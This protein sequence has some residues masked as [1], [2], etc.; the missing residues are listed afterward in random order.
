MKL[1]WAPSLRNHAA[2]EGFLAIVL[3]ALPMLFAGCNRGE[4]KPLLTNNDPSAGSNSV[5]TLMAAQAPLVAAAERLSK[6]DRDGAHLGGIKLEV[7]RRAVNVWWK[8]DPPADLR[9]EI[10]RQQQGGLTIN[11]QPA[12][13]SQK[14]L[15]Q[16]VQE[17]ASNFEA[18]PGLAY[19]GPIADGSGL[20]LGVTDLKR[21][22][23][24]PKI[25]VPAK[26]VESSVIKATTRANDSPPWWGGAVTRAVFPGA[27][28]CSTGFS[29]GRWSWGTRT[30][31]GILT[32]NH[33]APGGGVLFN[34]GAGQPIGMAEP[35][36]TGQSV[37]LD[38]LY[39]TTTSSG[40]RIFDGGVGTG[41]FTKP[42]LGQTNS[43]PG[44][45][46]CTSGAGTGVHCGIRVDSIK[47]SAFVF[48]S[49]VFSQSVAITTQVGGLM[50]SGPG[51]SGGP[52]FTLVSR[53]S[54]DGV[55][56][57]GIMVGLFCAGA[58]RADCGDRTAYVDMD[59]LIFHSASLITE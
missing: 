18:Y 10:N 24:F 14:E 15:L 57:A 49:G 2:L 7:D 13:F 28:A 30:S 51:D 41:E 5:K 6:I 4:K 32:A 9:D 58:R 48:P 25:R 21:A 56:A 54:T 27:G 11:L 38:S 50:S 46:V 22:A 1:N 42:V 29:V 35:R 31:T 55:A 33:C 16:A 53:G 45:F 17:I 3:I 20:E 19:A 44:M 37:V 12:Q 59:V 40:G 47:N 23:S 8:G 26:L 52:V 34:D 39:I 43:F 36:P